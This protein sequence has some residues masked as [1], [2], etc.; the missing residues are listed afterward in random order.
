MQPGLRVKEREG[1]GEVWTLNLGR[2]EAAP[3]PTEPWLPVGSC[4]AGERGQTQAGRA[5]RRPLGPCVG[6]S[7]FAGQTGLYL[8]SPL[9]TLSCPVLPW[10]KLGSI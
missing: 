4:Q 3:G 1:S 10:C 6:L 2:E 5:V 7:L 9:E 8:S